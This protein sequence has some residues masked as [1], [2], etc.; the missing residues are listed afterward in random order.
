MSVQEISTFL[1]MVGKSTMWQVSLQGLDRMALSGLDWNKL[2]FHV[3]ARACLATRWLQALG[4]LGSVHDVMDG[5]GYGTMIEATRFSGDTWQASVS[6]LQS[7]FLASLEVDVHML[8]VSTSACEKESQWLSATQL[9]RSADVLMIQSDEVIRNAILSGYAK[10]SWRFALEAAVL[11]EQLAMKV[12]IFG[13]SALIGASKMDWYRSMFF[14]QRSGHESQVSEVCHNTFINA[15]E[16]SGYAAVHGW[17][18]ATS[19]L[20]SLLACWMVPDLISC[21]SAISVCAESQEWQVAMQQFQCMTDWRIPQDELSFNSLAKSL[22]DSGQWELALALLAL[23]LSTTYQLTPDE[24]SY[25]AA[26]NACKSAVK[27]RH[28]SK[29]CCDPL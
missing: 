15:C 27:L 21:N 10:S 29:S 9:L 19:L 1:N 3:T 16:M 28:K 20:H 5:V 22:E 24:Y 14:L 23:M 2:C 17:Q 4:V 18:L 12:D 26:I 11:M 7:S 8:S 13:F 6:C 25:S